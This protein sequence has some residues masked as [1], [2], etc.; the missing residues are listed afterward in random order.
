MKGDNIYIYESLE[1]T[2]K[3][4]KE[5]A[6]QGCQHGTVV[7]AHSQTAGRG[8]FGR[9]F[10]SPA[11][12]GLYMS[13][14]LDAKYLKLKDITLITSATSVITS[15]VIENVTGKKC[16]IKWVNDL[17]LNGKKVCGILTESVTNTQTG[18]IDRVVV[19]I[20]ININT[21]DFPEDICD[22]A[23][24]IIDDSQQNNV[25][26]QIAEGIITYF[27]DDNT[28]NDEKRIMDEYR[29]KQILLGQMITVFNSNENYEAKAL[30]VDNKGRLVVQKADG[31]CEALFSGEVSVRKKS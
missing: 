22:I 4:A 3:T 18:Q 9:S 29:E 10:Y 27:R 11:E 24:S 13:I 2:N 20:G 7:I 31:T 26:D 5:L 16:G 30:D 19:G 1:S 15:R 14:V 12:T 17:I 23:T 28:F 8:R 21:K 25:R 6:T